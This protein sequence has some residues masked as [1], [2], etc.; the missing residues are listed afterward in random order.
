MSDARR[1]ELE[2][3]AAN[4]DPE[5]ARALFLELARAGDPEFHAALKHVWEPG[6]DQSAFALSSSTSSNHWT[7]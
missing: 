2:R 7:S 4:G 5:A 1:Q 6:V 3:L